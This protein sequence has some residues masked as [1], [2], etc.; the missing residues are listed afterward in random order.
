MSVPRRYLPSI[1]ALIAFEAVARLGSATHAAA[2]LSLTQSAISR[3]LKA[4][5]DQLGVVLLRREGRGFVLTQTGHEYVREV[6]AILQRL[7]RATISARTNTE[8][9]T[10]NLAI[11]PAFGMHWL[12]PRLRDFARRHPEVTVNLS[13]RLAP[14]D[15]RT[16][17]FDAAIHFGR[18]DWPGVRYLPLLPEIVVP[19]CAPSLIPTPLTDPHEILGHDLL[20]L[21]TRPRGWVRWMRALGL[22]ADVPPGMVFDQFSTMAQA[23]IHGLGIALLPTF[24]AEPYLADG[25]LVLASQRTSE[26]IG[27]YY[28]VW[29]E[30]REERSA[31]TSFCNWLATQTV[32]P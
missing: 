20:H 26:S 11:L 4:L 3:Q 24:F 16:S 30:D 21:D 8:G 28:L 29:P 10:L 22:D 27:S 7:G 23:A 19:V 15:F 1:S 18:E 17:T 12:A 5:E 32:N 31:L 2:E 6:R 13:T 14:F 25:Q 9:G